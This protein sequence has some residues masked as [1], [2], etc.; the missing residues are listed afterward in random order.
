MEIGTYPL[1]SVPYPITLELHVQVHDLQEHWKRCNMLANYVAEYGAY[2]FSEREWAENLISTVTNEFLE[3]V[4]SLAPANTDLAI[5]LRHGGN[6]LMLEFEHELLSEAT[7]G[8]AALL[9]ELAGQISDERYLGLLTTD[10]PLI[11][12]NQL[13]LAMVVH[14]FRA[15]VAA[16]INTE[17]SLASVQVMVPIRAE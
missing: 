17:T 6:D 9:S 16:R 12:F 7:G 13:G 8:Y 1:I 5:R 14:D 15:H 11:D 3:A 2:Q 10:R 4:S